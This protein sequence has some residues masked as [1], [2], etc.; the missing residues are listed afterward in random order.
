MSIILK[1]QKPNTQHFAP[2][3]IVFVGKIKVKQPTP[4]TG[5]YPR[6]DLFPSNTL[7]PMKGE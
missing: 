5:L 2:N 6:N 3:K 4:T 7:Y 1:G